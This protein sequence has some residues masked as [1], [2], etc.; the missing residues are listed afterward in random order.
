MDYMTCDI[1]VGSYVIF[2]SSDDLTMPCLGEVRKA[3]RCFVDLE[4]RWNGCYTPRRHRNGILALI[5]PG[6]STAAS[7]NA[8]LNRLMDAWHE[9]RG[10]TDIVAR[11]REILDEVLHNGEQA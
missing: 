2:F 7:R 3:T 10:S 6:I 8:L 9:T 1:P 4:P 5:P 11:Y